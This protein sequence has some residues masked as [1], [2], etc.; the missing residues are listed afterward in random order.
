MT[1]LLAGHAPARQ[2][3]RRPLSVPGYLH[4]P[5]IHH[6]HL[7]WAV[8]YARIGWRVFPCVP[9]GKTPAVR[10]WPQLATSDPGTIARWWRE[11]PDCN[12]AVACGLGSDLYVIDVDLPDGA[13]SL[14]AAE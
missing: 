4:D 10:A 6:D 2:G 13:G 5:A 1:A 3:P 9:G 8:Y 7:A 12:V 11:R 14:D